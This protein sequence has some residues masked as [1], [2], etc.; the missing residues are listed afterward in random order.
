MSLWPCGRDLLITCFTMHTHSNSQPNQIW[1]VLYVV[2]CKTGSLPLN[3]DNVWVEFCCRNTRCSVLPI[4][5][6]STQ[7][8]KAD[9]HPPQRGFSSPL[10][11]APSLGNGGSTWLHSYLMHFF[12]CRTIFKSVYFKILLVIVPGVTPEPPATSYKLLKLHLQ[13]YEVAPYE[14]HLSCL[15]YYQQLQ[16]QVK[17]LNPSL[18]AGTRKG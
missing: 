11:S 6:L 2:L 18:T 10:S 17:G 7:M 16:I 14:S 3:F 15:L 13:P 4:S 9:G 5:L 1:V 8:V 12:G